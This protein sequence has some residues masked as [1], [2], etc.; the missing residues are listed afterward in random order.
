LGDLDGILTRA[1]TTPPLEGHFADL[2]PRQKVA[3]PIVAVKSLAYD[4]GKASRRK[5]RKEGEKEKPPSHQGLAATL[6][7]R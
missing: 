2:S 3:P 6:A 5:P 4:R 1:A 7:S